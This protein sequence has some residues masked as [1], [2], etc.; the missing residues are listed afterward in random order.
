MQG[1]HVMS[2]CYCAVVRERFEKLLL[3]FLWNVFCWKLSM[4]LNV[5]LQTKEKMWWHA[6]EGL[7]NPSE[8]KPKPIWQKK[9]NRKKTPTNKSQK[10]KADV[11]YYGKSNV[12]S[13]NDKMILWVVVPQ[14]IWTEWSVCTVMQARVCFCVCVCQRLNLTLT[15]PHPC[16]CHHSPVTSL[17]AH[18]TFDVQ[19]CSSLI[20][21]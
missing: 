15:Q 18:L 14:T 16:S 12:M 5:L 11:V 7:N 6:R 20:K 2:C 10:Y 9:R 3:L 8:T 13:M 17:F 21:N 4:N 1:M 19:Y